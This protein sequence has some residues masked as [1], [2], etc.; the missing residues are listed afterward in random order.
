MVHFN[1]LFQT[2]RRL[3]LTKVVLDRAIHVMSSDIRN[4]LNDNTWD[5]MI[6]YDGDDKGYVDSLNDTIKSATKHPLVDEPPEKWEV[7]YTDEVKGPRGALLNKAYDDVD[8]D[9]YIFLENDW[10][11]KRISVCHA[12]NILDN[13]DHIDTVRMLTYPFKEH[14]HYN[15]VDYIIRYNNGGYKNH[16]GEMKT[17][18]PYQ[19]TFNPHIRREK[20]PVGE[21]P[22]EERNLWK[23]EPL[24]DE[25]YREKGKRTALLLNDCFIHFGV[26]NST[27]SISNQHY[28]FFGYD[29]SMWNSPTFNPP[30]M[31]LFDRVIKHSAPPYVS[32]E[33]YEEYMILLKEYIEE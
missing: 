20:Y 22:T 32:H 7:T 33:R 1:I 13:S 29:Y 23:V 25:W 10:W 11:W 15:V 18:I 12:L 6:A 14:S 21:F 30:T 26:K 28:G 27:G 2:T 24:Y 8:A 17:T 16:Y 5:I 19:W 9:Y 4:M 3:P 31:E